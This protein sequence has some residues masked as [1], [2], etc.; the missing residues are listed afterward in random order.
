MAS[1]PLPL[2]RLRRATESRPPAW[3]V[4]AG[5]VTA[6]AVAALLAYNAKLGVALL[7]AL[8]FVPV[9]FLQLP[10][11]ICGWVVLVF[12]SR[13]PSL[14][15]VPN[16][17]ELLIL[18]CWLGLLAGRRTHLRS[19]LAQHQAVLV[20]VVAFT[21]WVI[22]TLAWAPNSAVAA[23]AGRDLLYGV[24]AFALLLGTIVDR[25]HARWLAIAFV[26]GAALSVLWG[27]AKGGLSGAIGGAGA[28]TDQDGRFQAAAGD[29]NYLAAVLAPA[30]MLAGGLAF[31]RSAWRRLAL[32]FAVIVIAIGLAATQSRGGLVAAIVASLVALAIWRGR[33][34]LIGGVLVIAIAATAAFFATSPA[35]WERIYA[36]N[37]TGSGRVDIWQVAWRVANDHPIVGVG[38][39]QFPQVS[40]HYVRQPGAL[41]YVDLIVDKHIVVHNLYLELWAE[42]GIVGVLLF[43]AIVV[44]SIREA[45]RAIKRFDAQGDVEMAALA[46]TALLA[47]VG[48]LS[49]SF[50]LSNIA[51]RQI[52]ILLALGPVLA[53]IARLQARKAG[54]SALPGD[55][56][57]EVDMTVE[58]VS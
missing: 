23:R 28:V 57:D 38:I 24:V 10:L 51:N 25:R 55:L 48:M 33:R 9:A 19:R 20:G 53:E 30:I 12:F 45:W 18:A 49:A 26:T 54:E 56:A 35:A 42:T 8:C 27:A 41:D 52:W 3:I 21:L 4:A 40:P 14:G 11:A 32:L 29:P 58:L 34:R 44:A 31:R 6:F 43:L 50:F 36:G 13:A 15:G 1:R 37:T 7:V 22:M 2:P 46:R 47:V 16:R 17:L 5:V 39:N